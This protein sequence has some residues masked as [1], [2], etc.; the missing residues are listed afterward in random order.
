MNQQADEDGQEKS[1]AF[2]AARFIPGDGG[3]QQQGGETDGVQLQTGGS[4]PGTHYDL[5]SSPGDRQRLR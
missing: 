3:S 2:E 1:S 4:Q 5:F